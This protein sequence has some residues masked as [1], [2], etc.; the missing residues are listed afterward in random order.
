MGI[1]TVSRTHGSGGTDFAE[2]LAKR[3]DYQFVNRTFIN[4][5]HAASKDHVSI[6]GLFDDDSPSFL[7][8]F[9]ALKSNRNFFKVSLMANIYDYALKNNAVFVG[10]GAGIILS[11]INNLINIRVVRL[12]AERVKAIAQV[13]NIPYDDALD[14]VEKMDEGKKEFISHYFDMDVND[15]TLYHLAMNSSYITLDDA[16]DMVSEYAK[17]HLTI[18]HTA[19]TEQ[20]LKNRL[21]EKR[22][23]ILLFQLGMVGSYGKI[24]FEATENGVLT[25]KG[26]I[27]GEH[28][29]KELFESLNKNKEINKIEDHLKVGILSGMIY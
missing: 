15:P 21:L 28:E 11:E 2:A 24:N 3:L 27:G 5:D 20:F 4:N 18:A 29:K 8:R 25:V 14:L 7:E 17:K 26:V 13:K 12:L 6:F 22:A 10:M 1:I 23:E 19:E 16:L 9:Q